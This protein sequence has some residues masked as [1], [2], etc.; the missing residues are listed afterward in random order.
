M[1]I[2]IQIL[3]LSSLLYSCTSKDRF[4]V[5]VSKIPVAI[6]LERFDEAFYTATLDSLPKLKTSFPYFF[7][8]NTPDSI[9]V[10]KIQNTD[11]QALFAET[12]KVF[13]NTTA[14]S[15]ELRSLFAHLKYYNTSFREPKVVTMLSNIDYDYRIIY[16]DTLLLI[17]LD[18]YLGEQHP[19]YRDYPR[20]IKQ[21]NTK[22]HV[23]VDVAN[24]IISQQTGEIP[25]RQFL[26]KMITAGIQWYLLEAY[27]PA[28]EPHIRMGY[29]KQKW[30]WALENEAKVWSYFI[31]NNLLYST[32]SQLNQRF[33]DPAP[34]SKFYRLQDVDTPGQIGKWIGY[35][36]VRSFMNNND[37]S[38]QELTQLEPEL[39]FSKSKYKPKK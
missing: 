11:E 8:E 5:D 26:H 6:E 19:Y 22:D 34:F 36:I 35:R 31:E 2:Y 3:L 30:V 12:Q 38:L 21:T 10:A 25:S 39:I 14:L 23:V 1:R 9:W 16:T 17:S 15:Q 18:A 29:S 37:V 20:Y 13:P 7:P 27:M 28:K 32:D 24:A 4:Q 33:L